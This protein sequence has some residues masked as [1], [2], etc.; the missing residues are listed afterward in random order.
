MAKNGIYTYKNTKGKTMYRCKLA[1][2]IFKAGFKTKAEAKQYQEDYN[3]K[4][5]QMNESNSDERTVLQS[6]SF[7]KMAEAYLVSYEK[8]VSSETADKTKHI[9]RNVIIPLFGD[10]PMMKYTRIEC[11]EFENN[12]A[13][14][15]YST[16]H[17]NRILNILKRIFE[18]AEEVYLME[19]NPSVIIK[20]IKLSD[21]DKERM[22]NHNCWNENQFM[23]FLQCVEEEKYR[24]VFIFMYSTGTRIGETIALRWKD[25]TFTNDGAVVSITKTQR[26]RKKDGE[27]NYKPPKTDSSNR[28]INIGTAL[29]EILK[30]LKDEQMNYSTFD[31][32]WYVFG[33]VKPLSRT[34]TKRREES[35]C[36]L[37]GL[38][39]ITLHEFRHSHATNLVNTGITLT[40][41]AQRLGHSSPA[42]TMK[43]YAHAQEES[44]RQAVE[45][46]DRFCKN[47]AKSIKE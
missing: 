35:A 17:K 6:M 21:E 39:A 46:S 29:A 16:Q 2:G 8:N 36:E 23:N 15:K 5:R 13:K 40:A 30:E 28:K 12:V 38:D 10:K 3:F 1:D 37:A 32:S 31:T 19:N 20:S 4:Y 25:I 22:N 44:N 7:S 47:F 41:I 14:L 33:G 26:K 18:Y 43:T 27:K 45:Y 24:D 11:K 34:T 42:I 9:V